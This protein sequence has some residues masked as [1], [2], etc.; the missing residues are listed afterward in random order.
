MVYRGASGAERRK[1]RGL[2][3]AHAN[4]IIMSRDNART[5]E[6]MRLSNSIPFLR[7]ERSRIRG[8]MKI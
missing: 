4:N 2:S 8:P 7:N 1:N 3:R 5:D 6:N